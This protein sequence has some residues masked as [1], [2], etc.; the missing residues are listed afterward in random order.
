MINES[1]MDTNEIEG[2]LE[3]CA[4]GCYQRN[5]ALGIDNWSGSSLKG[6][7]RKY[8]GH[9]ER[10]RENLLRRFNEKIAPLGLK[11][12]TELRLNENRRQQRQLVIGRI[13]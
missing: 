9:Y 4:R 5:V 10:S 6:N 11:A 3:D 7:A 1:N 8:G 2:V 12:W 13:S